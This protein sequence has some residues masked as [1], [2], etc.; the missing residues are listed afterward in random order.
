MKKVID[1]LKQLKEDNPE[2]L[3]DKETVRLPEADLS[4]INPMSA[5][6]ELKRMGDAIKRKRLTAPG[7]ADEELKNLMRRIGK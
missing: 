2:A 1:I 3:A 4:K 5:P 6:S 7:L